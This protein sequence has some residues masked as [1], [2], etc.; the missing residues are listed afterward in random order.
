VIE[1]RAVGVTG[2][3]DLSE[4]QMSWLRP[5]L[6][7]ILHKLRDEHGTTDAHS[8][9]ALNADQDFGWSALNARLR[10]HAHVPFPSQ[11]DRWTREQQ[12][13]YRRL[14]ERCTS[15]KVYGSYFDV[16]LLFARNDGLLDA[17]SVIVAVWDGRRT[18]GTFDTVRKAANRGLPVIHVDVA[19]LRTH[20]PGCSCVAALAGHTLS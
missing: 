19:T 10:L 2:H 13:S 16:G 5:E 4:V 9:L 11:P 12:D 8:G 18:G 6:D 20:G 7:R 3:R 17:A 14:L 15:R 1:Y